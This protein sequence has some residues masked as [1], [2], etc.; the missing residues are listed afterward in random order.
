MAGDVRAPVRQPVP[1]ALRQAGLHPNLTTMGRDMFTIPCWLP[2]PECAPCSRGLQT[3][4]IRSGYRPLLLPGSYRFASKCVHS[5]DHLR[6]DC[7]RS[8]RFKWL[9]CGLERDGH[10][11]LKLLQGAAEGFAD[12]DA[13]RSGEEDGFVRSRTECARRRTQKPDS[14]VG[15][16]F[17]CHA[18]EDEMLA[19]RCPR[20][21][22]MSRMGRMPG[23]E[24]P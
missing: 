24:L 8:V 11:F 17:R 2:E 1:F 6:N 23:Q 19:A 18:G 20:P 12:G 21:V 14:W 5:R 9:W 4:T 7:Y 3:G 22:L 15:V 16:W 13:V 10:E